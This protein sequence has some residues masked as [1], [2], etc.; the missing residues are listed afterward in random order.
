MITISAGH[1]NQIIEDVSFKD[2]AGNLY[3]GKRHGNDEVW[4]VRSDNPS[5]RG[6]WTP[7]SLD[8]FNLTELKGI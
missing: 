2:A 7:D 8:A 3:H 1:A 5:L 4:L 6:W